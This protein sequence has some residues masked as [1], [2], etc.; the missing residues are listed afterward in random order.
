MNYNARSD[1]SD[2][3]S[4]LY[5]SVSLQS[6]VTNPSQLVVADKKMWIKGDEEEER[7]GEMW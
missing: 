2:F 1:P 6:D 4:N 7:R 3:V 5:T